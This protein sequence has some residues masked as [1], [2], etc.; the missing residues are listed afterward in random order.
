MEVNKIFFGSFLILSLAACSS[1]KTSSSVTEPLNKQ[2]TSCS[3]KNILNQFLV[4][5][6]DGSLTIETADSKEE[7]IRDFVEPNLQ[8][9]KRVEYDQRI[10]VQPFIDTE[11][12]PTAMNFNT[13]G[14][15]LVKAQSVWSEGIEGQNVK[16]AVVD[17]GLDYKHEQLK[18]QLAV[19]QTELNGQPG[20]DDDGNGLIDDVYG[21]DFTNGTPTPNL[22]GVDH[23]SHVAGIIAA[24]PV[25]GLMKGLAPKAKIIPSSFMDQYG[26]TVSGAIQAINYAVSRGA[27]IINASWGGN[28]CSE[29]L[30]QTISDLSKNNILFVA[31]AGNE[32]VDF[33]FMP[34]S[35]WSFPAVF[36][37][38]HQITVAW[39]TESDYISYN[40]NRSGKLVH[41]SAPGDYIWST[42]PNNA[43]KALSGTSMATPFVAGAAALLWSAR[44]TASVLQ[45]KK[46]ILEGVDADPFKAQNVVTR[47]RLNVEKS[48]ARL[49]QL[50]P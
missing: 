7:F 47:G 1:Q 5:W 37:F 43:Y 41:L 23:G 21:W 12:T 18:N 48:L 34:E 30:K 40:S 38:A 49:R 13:W 6:E 39:S 8:D 10:E 42:T 3:Q 46:A 20:L 25:S 36:D 35:Y 29:E 50:I 26:G 14:Q 27:K 15:D 22:S 9:I 44:P 45:I 28:Q 2:T 4:R 11:L 24:D 17:T 16:V 33:D 19:N 32:G 31:A